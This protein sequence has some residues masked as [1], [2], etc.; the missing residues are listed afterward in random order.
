[1][2]LTIG[3]LKELIKDKADTAY[4]AVN[5]SA[6]ISDV[7]SSLIISDNI[8]E[9]KLGMDADLFLDFDD[10]EEGFKNE[11]NTRNKWVIIG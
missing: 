7:D 3:R 8:E 2:I 1:M 9:Y 4:F 5:N 11:Y 10:K 6:V